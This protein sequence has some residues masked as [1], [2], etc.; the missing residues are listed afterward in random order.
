M[1]VVLHLAKLNIYKCLGIL[2]NVPTHSV[3]FFFATVTALSISFCVCVESRFLQSDD[4]RALF[5]Q[6]ILIR[7]ARV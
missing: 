6:M 7:I 1:I 5:A 2:Y 4:K 3:Y